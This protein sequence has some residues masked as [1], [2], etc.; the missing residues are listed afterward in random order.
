MTYGPTKDVNVQYSQ[1]SM[2]LAIF[3]TMITD[4][5]KTRTTPLLKTSLKHSGP[6]I[7]HFVREGRNG[8]IIFT[9]LFTRIATGLALIEKN[10]SSNK[11][12]KIDL[13]MRLQKATRY[14]QRICNQVKISENVA[15]SRHVPAVRKCLEDLIFR[16]KAMLRANNCQD[17]LVV[18]T[19]K[20]RN[21][22]GEEILS[23]EDSEDN[24]EEE[25]HVGDEDGDE[26]ESEREDD[27]GND[28]R[29]EV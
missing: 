24:S 12:E 15:M 20:N 28:V 10:F 4:L 21:I 27:V 1:W 19:R 18:G 25:E 14:L 9:L 6:F 7:S 22:E 5:E 17:L 8:H 23:Q 29:D 2:A 16:V 13:I 11:K 26:G 3:V